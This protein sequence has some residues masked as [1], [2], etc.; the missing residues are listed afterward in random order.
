MTDDEARILRMVERCFAAAAKES[1]FPFAVAFTIEAAAA[2]CGLTASS[3]REA[4]NRGELVA[5][6]RGGRWLIK[7]DNLLRWLE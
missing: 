2:A 4:I 6:K 5:V 1:R 7:R 3:I